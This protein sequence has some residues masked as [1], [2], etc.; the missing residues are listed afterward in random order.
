MIVQQS[1]DGLTWTNGALDRLMASLNKPPRA[2][3]MNP[4]EKDWSV[5]AWLPP[6]LEKD[7]DYL[8]TVVVLVTAGEKV[9]ACWTFATEDEA[10]IRHAELWT[11]WRNGTI[12]ECVRKFVAHGMTNP[13]VAGWA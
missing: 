7:N 9:T 5:H 6:L 4:V 10:E 13:W 11:A 1:S 3:Y 2:R 8:Y 12:D